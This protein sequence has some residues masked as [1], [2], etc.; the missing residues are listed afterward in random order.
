[1]INAVKGKQNH[2]ALA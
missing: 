2:L 1:M